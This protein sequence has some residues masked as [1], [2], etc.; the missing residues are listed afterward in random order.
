MGTCRRAAAGPIR[1]KSN[2][3]EIV[4][5]MTNFRGWTISKRQRFKNRHRIRR[6]FAIIENARLFVSDLLDR[7]SHRGPVTALH[8]MRRFSNF[9]AAMLLSGVLLCGTATTT[10]TKKKKR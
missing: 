3:R 10:T 8:M 9:M 7:I 4:I 6:Q 2:Y 1:R 5:W